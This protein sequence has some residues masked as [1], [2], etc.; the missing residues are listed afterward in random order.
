MKKIAIIFGGKSTEHEVST[1]SGLFVSKNIDTEKYQ[2]T[3]IYIDK[4]GN[5]YEYETNNYNIE[6]GKNL[7]NLK[8]IENVLEYLKNFDCIFPV[9]HGKYGEDGTIQGLFELLNIPYV[10]CKV[11]S[12]SLAMD[13]AYTKIVLNQAKI[14][15]APYKYIIKEKNE[16]TNV[17]E[18]LNQTKTSLEDI[19]KNVKKDLGFP[20]FIKPSNYGSSI[21]ITKANNEEELK[22]SIILAGKYDKKILIEKGITGKE[23]ECAILEKGEIITSPVGEI[24]SANEFYDYNSKYKNNDSK[25]TCHASITKEQE[26]EIQKIAKKAF[27]A[28]DCK[29]ISRIDFF[30]DEKGEIYLNEINTLPGF[31]QISMYPQ[32]FESMGIDNK[33]LVNSLIENEM[34]Y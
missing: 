25:T 13:K 11:L 9:L 4:K 27:L 22:K 23:L 26:N 1:S 29:E 19:S 6:F 12:S 33:E 34:S 10:G 21:G 8:P 30:L 17:D 28:L 14:K 2:K 31:T 15:Q 24:L 3:N 18:N 7:E 5:W 20:V 32:L 16:Y